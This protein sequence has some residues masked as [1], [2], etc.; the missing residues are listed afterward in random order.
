MSL[1]IKL[2]PKVRD[3][4][5]KKVDRSGCPGACHEWTAYRNKG[6][7]GQFN[8][9]GR[10]YPAHRIQWTITNHQDIPPGMLVC[11]SCDN[12]SCVN[13]N[14]LWLGTNADNTRDKVEKG[15]AAYAAGE[16]NGSAILTEDKVRMIREEYALGGITCKALAAKYGVSMNTISLT[17]N[18]KIWKHAP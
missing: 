10:M 18:R 4:Y 9:E 6:G 3:R 8:I 7:Y 16:A 11:H 13:P 2:T 12:P 1:L 14:H 5:E 17:I 15:R